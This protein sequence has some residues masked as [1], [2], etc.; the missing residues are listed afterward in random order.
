LSIIQETPYRKI[1]RYKTV[2]YVRYPIYSE[3]MNRTKML[4]QRIR[5][6]AAF[7][8][9]LPNNP[10]GFLARNCYGIIT[11]A[12]SYRCE[13]WPS[14]YQRS[15]AQSDHDNTQKDIES[16]YQQYQQDHALASKKLKQ[17]SE[18]KL[19]LW[20]SAKNRLAKRQRKKEQLEKEIAFC[21]LPNKKSALDILSLG[22][23]PYRHSRLHISVLK[24][25][26]EK[27]SV[28]LSQE[29]I[30]VTETE[31]AYEKSLQSIQNSDDEAK[32]KHEQFEKDLADN[33]AVF[34]E[35]L[36]HVHVLSDRKDPAKK[37]ISDSR[38]S[39]ASPIRTLPKEESQPKSGDSASPEI[40]DIDIGDD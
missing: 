39:P 4:S 30:A 18:M 2:N 8:E 9:S 5:V 27:N 31:K 17:D 34:Q 15:K 40:V 11:K 12:F 32:G 7:L 1:E 37:K 36:E 3:W 21:S 13:Y 33:E 22:I 14:W 38:P 6:S 16:N 20:N 29:A 19:S 25:R 35:K 10:D 24:K 23:R 26:A 28:V